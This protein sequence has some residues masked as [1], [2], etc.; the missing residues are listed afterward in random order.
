MAIK[1]SRYRENVKT[2][3]AGTGLASA[4]TVLGIR[5]AVKSGTLKCSTR[6]LKE[7]QRLDHVAAEVY[8]DGTLW[9]VIAAASNIGWPLQLPPGTILKIPMNLQAAIG[10]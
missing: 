5:S 10:I 9:W 1:T 4:R 8:G 2:T 3:P 6:V 7:G